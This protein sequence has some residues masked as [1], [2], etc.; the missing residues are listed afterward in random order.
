M[1]NRGCLVASPDSQRPK[2]IAETADFI[3]LMW[4]SLL[5]SGDISAS[6]CIGEFE[7][8]R[9]ECIDRIAA[10]VPLFIQA[11]EDIGDLR[12]FADALVDKLRSKR[13]KTIG[14]DITDLVPREDGIVPPLDLAIAAIESDD[15]SYKVTIPARTVENPYLGDTTTIAEQKFDSFRDVLL[16]VCMVTERDLQNSGTDALREWF[17][18]EI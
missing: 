7:L 15:P 6:G 4:P 2:I 1:S 12:Q 8:N 9:I 16:N 17:I 14:L 13:S 3:P 18:G 11:F 10:R 5:T